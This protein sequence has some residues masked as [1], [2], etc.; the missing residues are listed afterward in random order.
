MGAAHQVSRSCARDGPRGSR[1]GADGSPCKAGRFPRLSPTRVSQALNSGRR[2]L[3][4]GGSGMVGR[5]ILEHP[6]ASSFELLAPR[7]SEVD[8]FDYEA[9]ARYIGNHAPSVVVHAAGRVGGIQANI[10]EPVKFLLE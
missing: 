7:R 1:G 6:R 8:L 9:V 3:L 10:R 2:V 4:F 5:N